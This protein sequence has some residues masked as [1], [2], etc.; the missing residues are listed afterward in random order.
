M[1]F[2]SSNGFRT[3]AGRAEAMGGIQPMWRKVLA[4]H[5]K[6]GLV[7]ALLLYLPERTIPVA[8]VVQS[9]CHA[10]SPSLFNNH[11]SYASHLPA[12]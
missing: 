11:L 1:G 2:F 3:N 8:L 12:L 6:V 9:T 4:M 7:N 5:S 10:Q